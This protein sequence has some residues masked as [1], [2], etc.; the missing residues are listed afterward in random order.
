MQS[1]DLPLCQ[2]V[3]VIDVNPAVIAAQNRLIVLFFL[4]HISIEVQLD[5][6]V[7]SNIP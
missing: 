4:H 6:S 1:H 7:F 3:V 2:F 5:R